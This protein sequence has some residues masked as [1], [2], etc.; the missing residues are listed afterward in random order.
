MSM[1]PRKAVAPFLI[2]SLLFLCLQVTALQNVVRAQQPAPS[3]VTERGI[4]LYHQGKIKE[5]IKSLQSVVK[6][7]KDDA[8]AWY[9]L[10]LAL[11]RND[12]VKEA[13]KAFE[14]TI[15]LRPNDALAHTAYAFTLIQANRLKE[16]KAEAEQVL[17]LNPQVAEAHYLLGVVHLR[18]GENLEAK[19]EA[20]A[21]LKI[22]PNLP[23]ALLLKSQ[24]LVSIYFYEAPL[25]KQAARSSDV[26][27][28]TRLQLKEA[29]ESLEKYLKLEPDA[30]N[31]KLWREQLETLRIYA[32]EV[33]ATVDNQNTQR[34]AFSGKEVTARARILSRPEPEYTQAARQAG[35]SGTVVLRAV[36]DADGKVKRIL[37]IKSLGYDLTERAVQAARSI[38]FEPAIK[39]GHPVSQFI[40][41]EYNFNTY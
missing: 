32:E 6:Q 12:N 23:T 11:Y 1:K 24:A 30:S 15:K 10:G 13:R 8:D 19:N 33:N 22:N 21:A 27:N 31:A 37:V 35:I 38:K 20:E 18:E 7:N 29:A 26:T 5:A 41:I 3:T 28:S 16:G 4:D 36:F 40:Q 14:T 17:K 9:Y 2:T 25:T 39:D 34:R